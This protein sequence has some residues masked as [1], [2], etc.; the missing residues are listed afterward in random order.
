MNLGVSKGNALEM[1]L[2]QKGI[3]TSDVM[4]LGDGMNDREMLTMVGHNVVMDNACHKVKS[5]F[6]DSPIAKANTHD[7]VADYLERHFS[8]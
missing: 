4:A 7:G 2:A 3:A 8:L 1:L 5:L 6:P